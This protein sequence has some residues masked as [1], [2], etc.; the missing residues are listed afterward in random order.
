MLYKEKVL[1]YF[2]LMPTQ[3]AITKNNNQIQTKLD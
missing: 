2:I 1:N 3:F